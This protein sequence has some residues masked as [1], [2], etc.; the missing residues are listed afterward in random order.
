VGFRAVLD[1]SREQ[2]IS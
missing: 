2:K 1:K